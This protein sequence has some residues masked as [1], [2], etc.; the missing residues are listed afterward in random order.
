M[1]CLDDQLDYKNF[2]NRHRELYQE[3]LKEALENSQYPSDNIRVN[4]T[5]LH[6]FKGSTKM[7]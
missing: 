2:I 4:V 7:K 5:I 6:E 1:G 3:H